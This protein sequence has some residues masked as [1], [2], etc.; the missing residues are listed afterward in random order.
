M[1]V[2]HRL[3]H[4][5]LPRPRPLTATASSSTQTAQQ[6]SSPT[7]LPIAAYRDRIVASVVRPRARV[8]SPQYAD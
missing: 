6:Q 3:P 2:V 1:R 8:L 4:R 7:E 5:S